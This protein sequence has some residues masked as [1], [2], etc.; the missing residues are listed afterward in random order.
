MGWFSKRLKEPTTYIG[1]ALL[2]NGFGSIFKISE[3]QDVADAV[4]NSSGSLASGDVVTGAAI[5]IGG[6]A[7]VFMKE[8]GNK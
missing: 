8:K 7:G 1:L 6:L 5:L 4:A 3:A 2:I